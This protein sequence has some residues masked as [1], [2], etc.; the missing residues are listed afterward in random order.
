MVPYSFI[1]YYCQYSCVLYRMSLCRF[2]VSLC[3]FLSC[4][5]W[6]LMHARRASCQWVEHA[7]IYFSVVVIAHKPACKYCWFLIDWF[8]WTLLKSFCFLSVA[9]FLKPQSRFHINS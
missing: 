3:L 1:P 9:I 5:G 7:S 4:W 6:V 2:F 8:L